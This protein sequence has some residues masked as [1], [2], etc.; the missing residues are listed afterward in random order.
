MEGWPASDLFHFLVFMRLVAAGPQAT[1][2]C[3]VRRLHSLLFRKNEAVAYLHIVGQH[4]Y[5]FNAAGSA[6]C[7]F[8][9]L[10]EKQCTTTGGQ[11][12]TSPFDCGDSS[13]SETLLRRYEG[14]VAGDSLPPWRQGLAEVAARNVRRVAHG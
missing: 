8:R 1:I 4:C 10:S 13:S 3:Q 5:A 7:T 2:C 11:T 9:P 6:W 14:D 12:S